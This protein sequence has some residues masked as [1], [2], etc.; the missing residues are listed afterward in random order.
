VDKEASEVSVVQVVV[1]LFSR[2]D[3]RQ[4]TGSGNRLRLE[5]AMQRGD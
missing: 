1:P 2:D 4:E 3:G 5:A